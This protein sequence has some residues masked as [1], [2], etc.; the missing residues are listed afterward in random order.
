MNKCLKIAQLLAAPFLAVPLFVVPFLA[1]LSSCGNSKGTQSRVMWGHFKELDNNGAASASFKN[2]FF[3]QWDKDQEVR[4]CL[5]GPLP[6]K[7]DSLWLQAEITAA[8]NTWGAAVGRFLPVNFV[9]CNANPQLVVLFQKPAGTQ[10][11]VAPTIVNYMKIVD[12]WAK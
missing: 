1:V 12:E 5:P 3:F 10:G 6:A 4:A 8:I 2:A 11:S 7:V 9:A